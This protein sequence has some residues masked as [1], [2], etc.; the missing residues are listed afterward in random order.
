M[1][2]KGALEPLGAATTVVIDMQRLF[3]EATEWHV[4]GLHAIV[5]A[6]RRLVEH[7]PA[8]ALFTRFVPP[9]SIAEA[10]GRWQHYYRRWSSVLLDRMPAEMIDLMP[11]LADLARPDTICDKT[12]FSSL[13]DGAL[14]ERLRARR[15]DTLVLAGAETDVCV[16]GTALQAV[17]HGYRVVI[18]SDAVA[19]SSTA[20]H[21]G[22]METLFAR[23]DRQIDVATVDEICAAWC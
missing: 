10:P 17:D 3:A 2:A 7:R 5:P 1:T 14:G 22:A 20:G 11:E 18:A 12:T 4:P 8:A 9:H 6:V 23:Y 15:I 16:L 21:R 13:A 19:S